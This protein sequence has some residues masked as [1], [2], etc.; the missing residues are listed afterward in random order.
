MNLFESSIF[1]ARFASHVHSTLTTV[2][3]LMS[4]TSLAMFT[5][6]RKIT[7]CVIYTLRPIPIPCLQRL[8]QFLK[9]HGK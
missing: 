7:F 4:T 1:C 9:V 5:I 2:N 6:A 3:V 8:S